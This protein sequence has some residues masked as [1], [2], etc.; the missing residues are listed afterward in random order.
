[1]SNFFLEIGTEELPAEFARLALPQ[2][3]GLICNDLA[4]ERIA[5]SDLLINSTPRRLVIQIDNLPK[6][7]P[8]LKEER[9]G[10][11][12][13]YEAIGDEPGSA[14]LGFAKRCGVTLNNL[15]IRETPK[16]RFVFARIHRAGR[17]TVTI[18]S[19]RIP[20]WIGGIQ[21][22]RF[23]RWGLQE[24]RFSR[25][26]RWIVALFD[27]QVIPLTLANSIPKIAS[28]RISY[29]HRLL[30][31]PIQVINGSEYNQTV[32]L[33][34]VIVDRVK[35]ANIIAESIQLATKKINAR[36]DISDKLFTELVDLV[37]NPNLL[38]GTIPDK[39]LKLPPEIL[40]TVMRI[41]Q[42]YIPLYCLHAEKDPL[43][44][45]AENTLMPEFL[46]VSNGRLEATDTIS[47]GNE[48]VLKARLADA[49]FFLEVDRQ[50]TSSQRHEQLSKVVFAE[51]LGSLKDR[52]DRILWLTKLMILSI[53][54]KV[55][56]KEDAIRA[57]ALCKHDL[58]SQVVGEFPE[59]QG[60]IGGKYLLAE[61]ETRGTALAILEHYMPRGAGD[62]LPTSAAGSIV[63]LAERLELII[64]IFAK[65]ERPSGSS[66]PYALRRAGNGILQILWN[67]DW[68]LNL[69]AL[70][71]E[72]VD[73]W[74]EL[75]PLFN[76]NSTQLIK[77]LCQFLH[78]RIIFLLG[79]QNIDSDLVQAVAGESISASR[80]L[81]DPKDVKYRLG[82]LRNL[83]SQKQLLSVQLVVQRAARLAEKADLN[84]DIVNPTGL[85]NESLFTS[86]SEVAVGT[87][88]KKLYP[89]VE[90][91]E[92]LQL[93]ETL[94]NST[95]TLADFF[96]GENSVMVMTD[97]LEIR[98]NRLNL[99]AILRNQANILADFSKLTN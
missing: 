20:A 75:F 58:V 49:E 68:S 80:L 19:E 35:R 47:H 39:Y 3:E 90:N 73:Y 38:K 84:I 57:A 60:I 83:R 61:G 17:Q 32:A 74:S 93:S 48:R 14:V 15:E 69:L 45:T 44:L 59:L 78:Q 63:A 99:L 42:R 1:M 6:V 9:K 53:P 13:S 71:R 12:I 18:L 50:I 77:D 89:L 27:N 92:Y 51:G 22:K 96:D 21:G 88:L 79:E 31:K 10:P 97:D 94:L 43:V 11:P 34:Q 72:A 33:G 66:D 70:L 64:S 46:F 28:S 95:S 2:L 56:D 24:Q 25:P 30:V 41:H 54:I 29:G 40:S 8:D 52:N 98:Q 65:N 67:Q 62:S 23:M 81:S 85:V 37:E 4:S 16:G 76:I 82:H 5:Y 36:V 87:L 55:E 26:I 7:Q 86:E 91:R